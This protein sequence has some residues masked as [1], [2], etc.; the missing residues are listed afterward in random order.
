MVFARFVSAPAEVGSLVAFGVAC[1]ELA[2]AVASPSAF[3]LTPDDAPA[4]R[5]GMWRAA[6]QQ[7]SSSSDTFCFCFPEPL[8][9][10]C[11]NEM[12]PSSAASASK[13][14]AFESWWCVCVCFWGG[15]RAKAALNSPSNPQSMGGAMY[16]GTIAAHTAS[17]GCVRTRHQ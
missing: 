16:S 14:V 3:R 4:T 13:R 9:N 17:G 6:K 11:V 5:D 1:P 7:S 15:H 10:L 2:L 12:C 8:P